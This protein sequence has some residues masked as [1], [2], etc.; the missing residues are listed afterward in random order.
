V[1]SQGIRITGVKQTMAALKAFEP[2]VYKAMRKTIRTRIKSVAKGATGRYAGKY[3]VSIRDA[4]RNPGASITGVMGPQKNRNDW[5]SP[6]SRAVIFE[7]AGSRSRGK[8][9]GAAAAIASFQARFGAP[10]RFLWEEWDSQGGK[11]IS[12]EVGAEIRNAERILQAKLDA[13]G[14]GY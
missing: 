14:E 4:G 1:A 13:A 9:P 5:S 7:F 11:K 8:T 10:G 3:K 2:D 6:Q 12:D